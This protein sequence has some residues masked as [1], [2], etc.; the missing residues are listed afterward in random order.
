[1]RNSEEEPED[2]LDQNNSNKDLNESQKPKRY[3]IISVFDPSLSAVVAWSPITMNAVEVTRISDTPNL[4][5]KL[6]KIKQE[7]TKGTEISLKTQ[8]ETMFLRK[9]QFPVHCIPQILNLPQFRVEQ[10]IVNPNQQIS[11]V[12]DF[13]ELNITRKVRNRT[14][15]IERQLT[16]TVNQVIS[17]AILEVLY[18]IFDKHLK[19]PREGNQC[20]IL[21]EQDMDNYLI[22]DDPLYLYDCAVLASSRKN[23]LFLELIK[24]SQGELTDQYFPFSKD[25]RLTS[26]ATTTERA[27]TGSSADLDLV[28]K[29]PIFW[30]FPIDAKLLKRKSKNTTTNQEAPLDPFNVKQAIYSEIEKINYDESKFCEEMISSSSIIAPFYIHFKEITYL[31][32]LFTTADL[33]FTPMKQKRLS[34]IVPIPASQVLP[35]DSGTIGLLS[36]KNTHRS[37]EE[38]EYLQG[39]GYQ[40]NYTQFMNA[41]Y[42]KK[43]LK[44]GKYQSVPML[45]FVVCR[46][47]H[48]IEIISTAK[49]ILMPLTDNTHAHRPVYFP[50]VRICDVPLEARLQFEMSLVY[51]TGHLNRLGVVA[52]SLFDYAGILRTG[53]RV[54]LAVF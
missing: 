4:S 34:S 38:E 27:R 21:K 18:Q 54:S 48:G 50:G 14:C 28:L 12:I 7:I 32:H 3:Y 37:K 1:M 13:S 26:G 5:K 25:S 36:N 49:K 40:Q 39:W 33:R 17:V 15:Q 51:N 19:I 6:L 10:R 16:D 43:D 11:I 35:K 47:V 52:T 30:N 46:L 23:Q 8:Y 42:Q 53:P 22:G 45:L 31:S 20:Y 2:S 9:R 41:M 24:K 29:N 44:K